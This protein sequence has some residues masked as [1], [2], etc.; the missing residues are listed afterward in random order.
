MF[1]VRRTK[2]PPLIASCQMAFLQDHYLLLQELDLS[3]WQMNA[4]ATAGKLNIRLTLVEHWTTAAV[5]HPVSK[6]VNPYKVPRPLTDLCCAKSPAPEHC[7]RVDSYWNSWVQRDEDGQKQVINRLA[8]RIHF[9]QEEICTSKNSWKLS[10]NSQL[11]FR[12]KISN[13]W[14]GVWQWFSR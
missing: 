5:N 7:W 12:N 9:R 2:M 13:V 3:M 1:F 6:D 14:R 8:L 4:W 10:G 11:T